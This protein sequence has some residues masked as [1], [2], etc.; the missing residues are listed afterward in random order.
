MMNVENMTVRQL[1]NA[2]HNAEQLLQGLGVDIQCVMD[3]KLSV[4]LAEKRISFAPVLRTIELLQRQPE[5]DTHWL[6]GATEV[7][8]EHIQHYY[9]QRHR[10]QLPALAVLATAVEA[11]NSN[12][13]ACPK[14]LSKLLFKLQ[15]DLFPHMEKEERLIFPMLV[16]NK[17]DYIYCQV[18]S[19]LHHHDQHSDVLAQIKTLT[20]NFTPPDNASAKWQELYQQLAE[21]EQE[22]REH[23]RLENEILFS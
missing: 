23:I 3:K 4:T 20:N 2:N 10:L 16:A 19:I 18:S 14:G 8:V 17:T 6:L 12:N 5:M 1:L 22:L 7:L 11:A 9:H 21:F 15:Q 13:D